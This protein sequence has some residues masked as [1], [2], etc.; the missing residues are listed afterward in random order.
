MDR[1]SRPGVKTRQGKTSKKQ[2]Q[3]GIEHANNNAGLMLNTENGPVPHLE[4]AGSSMRSSHSGARRYKL[5][6]LLSR[7]VSRNKPSSLGGEV[8]IRHCKTATLLRSRAEMFFNAYLH[9]SYRRV[10]NGAR[11]R[12]NTPRNPCATAMLDIADKVMKKSTCTYE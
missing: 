6:S 4:R 11:G 8:A 7:S 2:D 12:S 1:G 3:Q 5:I 9:E 10:P